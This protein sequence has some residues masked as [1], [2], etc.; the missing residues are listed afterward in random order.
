MI[1]VKDRIAAIDAFGR[2]LAAAVNERV[3]AEGLVG[4]SPATLKRVEELIAAEIASHPAFKFEEDE[5][6]VLA[7]DFE[8]R[9]L[10]RGITAKPFVS[11]CRYTGKVGP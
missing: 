5:E 2:E 9:V 11:P 10:G 3:E 1:A 7:G 6:S 4:Q 8:F